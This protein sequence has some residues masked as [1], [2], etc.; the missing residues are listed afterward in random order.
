MAS[1]I[2][3]QA[4]EGHNNHP[5]FSVSH[6]KHNSNLIPQKTMPKTAKQHFIKN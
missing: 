2:L 6:K 4:L 1:F 3:Q 5:S